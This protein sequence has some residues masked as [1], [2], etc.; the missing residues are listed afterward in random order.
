MNTDAMVQDQK[1]ASEV[2]SRLEDAFPGGWTLTNDV[3][4]NYIMDDTIDAKSFVD[5]YWNFV[6]RMI[7][8]YH[9]RNGMMATDAD[10]VAAIAADDAKK[11]FFVA[12]VRLSGAG[13]YQIGTA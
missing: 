9:I 5:K 10:S 4:I 13:A 11:L 3:A 6:Y 8:S 12:L 2:I 1:A 7:A